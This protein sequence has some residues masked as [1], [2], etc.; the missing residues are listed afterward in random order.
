MNE[1]EEIEKK[2]DELRKRIGMPKRTSESTIRVL[3]QLGRMPRIEV[4]KHLLGVYERKD[5]DVK[6]FNYKSTKKE[7]PCRY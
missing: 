1:N 2:Y 4:L 5:E 6:W 7:V 3:C